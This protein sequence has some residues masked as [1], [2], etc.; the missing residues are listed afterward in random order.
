MVARS[1]CTATP[2]Y[3]QL[4]TSRLLVDVDANLGGFNF[5]NRSTDW[6]GLVRVRFWGLGYR[7]LVMVRVRVM[8]G[9]GNW[10]LEVG[11]GVES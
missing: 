6:S 3:F 1:R 2:R 5:T 7:I 8:V 11:V 9:V 4:M 10:R